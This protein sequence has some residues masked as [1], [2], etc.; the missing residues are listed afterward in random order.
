MR[1][2]E[3]KR[4]ELYATMRFETRVPKALFEWLDE[5]GVCE[6][7]AEE[8]IRMHIF[9]LADGRHNVAIHPRRRELMA[10]H[11]RQERTA[12]RNGFVVYPGPRIV[13][14]F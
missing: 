4:G 10:V 2:T 12:L 6:R 14:V 11:D 7:D 13:F 9:E 3:N 5:Y 8:F 1:F